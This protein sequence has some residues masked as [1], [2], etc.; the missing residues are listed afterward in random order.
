MKRRVLIVILAASPLL[1]AQE[2]PRQ[3]LDE[4]PRVEDV[5]GLR[6]P[7]ST[8][9]LVELARAARERGLRYLLANQNKDGS[10]GSHDPKIAELRD[11]GFGLLD[12]GAQDA[13]RTACTAICAQ[14]LMEMAERPP[15]LQ[16]SLERAIGDLLRTEKFAFQPGG[17]FNT[18]G[19]GYKLDFLARLRIHGG[20]DSEYAA[21]IGPAAQV[22]IDGLKRYQQHQGGWGYYAGQMN[23]FSSMSFNTAFFV[24]ALTRAKDAGLPVD[25]RMIADAAKLVKSARFPDGS[26][27]YY[28]DHKPQA[29]MALENLAS[30]ARTAVCALAL[31]DTGDYGE[32]DLEN[33]LLIFDASE[34]YLE[35]G[36][37][38]I[39]PHSAVQRISGY[40]FFFGYAYATEIALRLGPAV[41]QERWDRFAW[42]MIR[43]QEADGSWWDTPAASYGDKWGT[44]FALQTLN[45]Y[46]IRT[47]RK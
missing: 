4:L 19:Y 15:A 1:A 36:R 34:N 30:G 9:K 29:T 14:A 42:T 28:G 35:S 41:P 46:L 26:F 17:T 3:P 11:F 38:L 37:K 21:R 12:R 18:W 39:V 33:A 16:A 5:H 13:V 2:P 31:H 45:R 44:G 22:C 43:T 24:S 8:E 32:G 23:D 6:P 7:H 47:P 10:W 25:Q 27:S 20:D 40:F